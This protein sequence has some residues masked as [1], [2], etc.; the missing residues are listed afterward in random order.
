MFIKESQPTSER[1]SG[2]FQN[3]DILYFNNGNDDDT[4]Q[5][6]MPSPAKLDITE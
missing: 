2:L 5:F 4:N 1:P 3:E 6:N